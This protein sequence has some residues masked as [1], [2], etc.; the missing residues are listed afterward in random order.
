MLGTDKSSNENNSLL[1]PPIISLVG[2]GVRASAR[3]KKIGSML[4]N[5]FEEMSIRMN[6]KTMRLSVFNSNIEAKRLYEK[7]G[8]RLH[9]TDREIIYYFKSIE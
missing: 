1:I 6:M 5:K 7:S 8:W 9:A 2:I 4:M 3:G